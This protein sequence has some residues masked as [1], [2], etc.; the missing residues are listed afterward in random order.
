MPGRVPHRFPGTAAPAPWVAN[1]APQD[2]RLICSALPGSF[3][4]TTPFSMRLQSLSKGV[5]FSVPFYMPSKIL[6]QSSRTES[7]EYVAILVCPGNTP[8][9]ST[10]TDGCPS[11]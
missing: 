8:V 10:A 5:S 7:S 6:T 2:S 9:V 3:A 4:L 1:C 11:W